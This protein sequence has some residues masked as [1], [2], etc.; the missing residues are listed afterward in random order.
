MPQKRYGV[1]LTAEE[2]QQLEQISRTGKASAYQITRA[3]ILLKVDTSLSEEGWKDAEISAALDMSVA[4]IERLRKQF[5]AEG[6][7]KCLQRKTRLYERLLDG[8][9][10]AN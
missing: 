2:C 7:P 9:Q 6:V 4:R 3:Q 5:V 1:T 10:E 8:E